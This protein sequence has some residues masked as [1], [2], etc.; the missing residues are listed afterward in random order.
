MKDNKSS[1]II[2]TSQ[3]LCNLYKLDLTS[4]NV[5]QIMTMEVNSKP[6]SYSKNNLDIN[7]WHKRMGHI[8]EQHLKL[9]SRNEMVRGL[10]IKPQQ[11]LIFCPSCLCGKQQQ[12]RFPIGQSRKAK[13]ILELIHYDICSP[14][15]IL[16]IRR[17]I[18]FYFYQ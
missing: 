10:N 17:E 3:R 4:T 16:S 13:E 7:K 12:N 5:G 14:M 9:M 8:G 18:F 15:Q 11:R 1:N 2:C 6:Y